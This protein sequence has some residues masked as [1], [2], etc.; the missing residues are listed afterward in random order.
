MEIRE[1]GDRV[2]GTSSRISSRRPDLLTS[3][4]LNRSILLQ[5]NHRLALHQILGAARK[6]YIPHTSS[7]T[8]GSPI[9]SPS[10][11]TNLI[12]S[13]L[14]VSSRISQAPDRRAGAESKARYWLRLLQA[15]SPATRNGLAVCSSVCPMAWS[16][17]TS[18]SRYRD[19]ESSVR[20]MSSVDPRDPREA[21]KESLDVSC[22]SWI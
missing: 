6:E 19:A 15:F 14:Q 17:C 12:K 13:P 20:G 10:T 21:S 8:T 22:Q 9:G 18:R 4:S 16:R 3:K 5:S 7:S 2:A 1:A 11:D